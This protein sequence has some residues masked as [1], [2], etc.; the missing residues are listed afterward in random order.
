M[1]QAWNGY[2]FHYH[3]CDVIIITIITTTIMIIKVD[4]S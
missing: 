3:R 2:P 1:T 4:W